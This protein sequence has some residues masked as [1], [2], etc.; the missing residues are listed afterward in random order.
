MTESEDAVSVSALS[1]DS[2]HPS[3]PSDSEDVQAAAERIRDR[4]R[5]AQLRKR[6][7]N[8]ELLAVAQALT[9][10]RS[11]ST[12]TESEDAVS[13]STLSPDS[14]PPSFPSYSEEVQAAAERIRDRRRPAHLQRERELLEVEGV[15]THSVARNPSTMSESD[16]AVSTSAPAAPLHA[17]AESDGELL[18]DKKRDRLRLDCQ[19]DLE[20]Q[21]ERNRTRALLQVGRAYTATRDTSTMTQSDGA[22]PGSTASVF[23]DV[24]AESHR[25]PVRDEMRDELRRLRSANMRLERELAHERQRRWTHERELLVETHAQAQIEVMNTSTIPEPWEELFARELDSMASAPSPPNATAQAELS[26]TLPPDDGNFFTNLFVSGPIRIYELPP[27]RPLSA[28]GVET[29][30]TMHRHDLGPVETSR[31][32]PKPRSKA[33]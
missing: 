9:A 24:T 16:G 30:G 29:A 20:Q 3:F 5:R 21:R 31:L 23:P 18:G 19:L 10:A 8:R 25:P 32:L 12:M 1:P 6:K 15:R 27:P 7:H 26:E 22:V 17:T 11:T 28:K 2:S 13:V 4:R 14:S 33:Q